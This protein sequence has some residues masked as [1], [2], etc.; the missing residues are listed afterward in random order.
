MKMQNQITVIITIRNRES[1]R[2]ENQVNS[3]R[4][5][6]ANPTIHVVDYGSDENYKN[7]YEKLCAK[8]NIKFTHMYAEGL[9]WN[10][11][12][13]IN[14][15]VR[16]ATTSFIVT[17][18]VDMI[19]TSNPFQWCLDNFEEKCIYHIPTYWLPKSANFKK[20]QAAGIGNSG[21]FVFSHIQAF[22]DT[23]G[24]DERFVYWGKEDADFPI[25]LR[26]LGYKQIWLPETEHKLYHQWHPTLKDT[27]YRPTT[28]FHN[29][30]RF[31]FENLITPK[32]NQNYGENLEL[33]DRPILNYIKNEKPDIFY[34]QQSK[35]HHGDIAKNLVSYIKHNNFVKID[36]GKRIF[37]NINLNPFLKKII[38]YG[39]RILGLECID[40]LNINFDLLY[41]AIQILKN[42]KQIIDYYFDDKLEN[43]YIL[44]RHEGSI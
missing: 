20:A 29:S 8:L 23:N 19:Y 40:Y 5:Y 7:Q 43:I 31:N 2:I 15:G 44:S 32:I 25:R 42:K 24:Y 16:Q 36:I 18:D 39:I 41:E 11:C 10:K 26:T 9:P 12:R 22:I 13:A 6:G 4:K 14:Y 34:I 28:A 21:G 3:I 33:K 38:S 27:V 30:F 37:T 1:S 17:S 35:L